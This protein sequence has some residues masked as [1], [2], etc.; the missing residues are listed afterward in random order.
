MSSDED[1]ASVARKARRFYGIELRVIQDLDIDQALALFFNRPLVEEVKKALKFHKDV[2][3]DVFPYYNKFSFHNV[4]HN[5]MFPFYPDA[6]CYL[7]NALSNLERGLAAHDVS[8]NQIYPGRIPDEDLLS[9]NR[10]TRMNALNDR[11]KFWENLL[12]ACE[13]EMVLGGFG[14]LLRSHN[15]I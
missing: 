8:F 2:L 4:F 13:A 3:Q 11:L 6:K 15:F 5:E 12:S 1:E 9:D 14:G 7:D 10:E